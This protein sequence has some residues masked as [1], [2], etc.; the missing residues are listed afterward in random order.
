MA[1]HDAVRIGQGDVAALLPLTPV[2]QRRQHIAAGDEIELD[3]ADIRPVEVKPA[4]KTA[5]GVRTVGGV[6]RIGL[7]RAPLIHQLLQVRFE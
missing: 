4:G 6:R 1:H 5:P 3:A 7:S 2:F